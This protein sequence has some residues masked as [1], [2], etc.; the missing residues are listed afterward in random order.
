MDMLKLLCHFDRSPATAGRSGKISS[1]LV[2]GCW[3]LVIWYFHLFSFFICLFFSLFVMKTPEPLWGEISDGGF[4]RS[5][6][7][8]FAFSETRPGNRSLSNHFSTLLLMNFILY[9]QKI[10]G[11]HN[12]CKYSDSFVR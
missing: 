3:C 12:N 7:K 1:Y 9:L 11:W 2:S 4:F 5:P 10:S 8:R 6:P